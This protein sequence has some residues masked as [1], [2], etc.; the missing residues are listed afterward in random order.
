MSTYVRSILFVLLLNLQL[1][2]YNHRAAA[3]SS[4]APAHKMIQLEY[5]D[6]FII[7]AQKC[8]TTSLN[9]LLYRH[10]SICNQGQKEKH[11]FSDK[12][13]FLNNYKEHV[14]Y[15]VNQF[16][17]CHGN[18]LSI[19]A[20]PSYVWLEYVPEFIKLSYQKKDLA[21]KKF[22]LLLREPVARLF[23]TYQREL[24]V[25]LRAYDENIS[26]E[27]NPHDPIRS[28][29][30]MAEHALK[31]CSRMM[32]PEDV[33]SISKLTTDDIGRLSSEAESARIFTFS[34]WQQSEPGQTETT[35]G[36]FLE[37]IKRW[38][39]IIERRQ[40]MIVNFNDLVRNS[41]IIMEK[42]AA[43]LNIDPEEWYANENDER[44]ILL[45]PPAPWNH[46]ADWAP[47]KLDCE[48]MKKL[49]D[50]YAEHNKNLAGFINGDS[51]R[52]P[53]EPLFPTWSYEDTY[54]SCV[55]FA[56][57]KGKRISPVPDYAVYTKN[58]SAALAFPR[59]PAP[60]NTSVSVPG[61]PSAPWE[62]DDDA[63]NRKIGGAGA[64][65]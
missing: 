14:R 2:W 12:K 34:G 46:Y 65:I 48:T 53:E 52:P 41:T 35:R 15:Y 19:D 50:H 28:P 6:I 21:R 47:S 64:A 23:S 20:T 13:A 5:P 29:E 25:C 62:S 63:A 40:L 59:A 10:D 11:F 1:K 4:D 54:R 42:I 9:W 57:E 17:E 39:G 45:P 7:G 36:Y 33:E 37:Q 31:Y 49:W 43:F 3:A 60:S 56:D 18:R 26:R 30:E 22:L 61:S 44:V 32:H 55:Y 27:Y 51:T 58:A 16:K 38:L 8:G 24:R